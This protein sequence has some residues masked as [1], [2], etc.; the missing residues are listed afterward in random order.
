VLRRIRLA[1]ALLAPLLAGCGPPSDLPEGESPCA[2]VA[3]VRVLEFV[4]GD[5]CDVEYLD[6]DLAGEEVR[7]RLLGVDTPEI[8]HSS[9]ESSECH[10][11]EAWTAAS[12]ELQ[13][14]DAWLTFDAECTDRYDRTLAYMFRSSDRFFLNRYL[15]EEGHARTLSISPNT[16]LADDFQQ[17][18]EA[19][20]LAARGLWGDPCYGT[21]R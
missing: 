4:D 8:N 7:V 12:D 20:Q 3:S 9:L 11:L 19:A 16:T 2:P 17:I 13:G 1:F 5:T 6:G 14:E 10:A 15:L 18:E 21:T